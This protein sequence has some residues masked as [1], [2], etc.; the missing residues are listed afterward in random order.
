MSNVNINGSC[1][2]RSKLHLNREGSGLLAENI[3]FYVKLK[4]G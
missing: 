2:I 3:A 1:L 4:P